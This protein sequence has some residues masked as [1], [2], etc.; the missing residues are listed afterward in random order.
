[1]HTHTYWSL[2][3]TAL[4]DTLTRTTL[5]GPMLLNEVRSARLEGLRV[6]R[7]E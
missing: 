6:E 4:E 2:E 3:T 5:S 1:M 7:L